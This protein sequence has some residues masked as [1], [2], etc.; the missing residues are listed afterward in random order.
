MVT[1]RAEDES[2][3]IIDQSFTVSVAQTAPGSVRLV[4]QSG[5]DGSFAFTSSEPGLNLTILTANRHPE[6]AR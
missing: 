5:E 1:Y 6:E 4:V 3:N 2:G